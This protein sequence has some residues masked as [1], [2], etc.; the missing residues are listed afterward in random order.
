MIAHHLTRPQNG[1]TPK[2][3]TV[4]D[5]DGVIW[6]LRQAHLA[7][8]PL[9]Q[10]PSEVFIARFRADTSTIPA[11]RHQ[12]QCWLNSVGLKDVADDVALV[13]TELMGN[14]AEHGCRG[15]PR[16]TEMAIRISF[17]AVL[18]RVEVTDLSDEQPC[19]RSHSGSRT[20]GRGLR[21]VDA[22]SERWGAEGALIGRGKTVWA[23]LRASREAS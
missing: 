10:R 14:A 4:D 15:L 9:S 21:L 1:D 8:E 19:A 2:Q 20:S 6:A 12:L 5:P 7:T 23:D 22:F 13:S 3:S 17:S 18:V 16:D 11:V